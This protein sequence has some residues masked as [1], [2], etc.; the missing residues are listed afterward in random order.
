[1]TINMNNQAQKSLNY[2]IEITNLA[3]INEDSNNLL[4]LSNTEIEAIHGGLTTAQLVAAG[5]YTPGTLQGDPD[6]GPVGEEIYDI[7]ESKSRPL[8]PTEQLIYQIILKNERF[9]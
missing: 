8:S 3:N 9:R 7:A 2:Q 1:M 5:V 4:D 6:L